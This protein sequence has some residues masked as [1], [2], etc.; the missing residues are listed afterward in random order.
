MIRPPPRWPFALEAR[1][2]GGTGPDATTFT[3]LPAG[4]AAASLSTVNCNVP[5]AGSYSPN[6]TVTDAFGVSATL[7]TEVAI[8]PAPSVTGFT[9]ASTE[10]TLGQS[11]VLA[12]TLTRGV[13][14]FTYAYAGLP[15]AARR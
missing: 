5:V 7:G 13:A 3:G 9:S 11:T 2:S 4:C 12:V 10:F 8:Y 14:P 6:V 15:P 1:W